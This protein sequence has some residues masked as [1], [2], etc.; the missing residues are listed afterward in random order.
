MRPSYSTLPIETLDLGRVASLVLDM[1]DLKYQESLRDLDDLGILGRLGEPQKCE[2]M[3]SY[4][5]S[6]SKRNNGGST[7]LQ[8][9]SKRIHS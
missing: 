5:N 2:V 6:S 1:K 7:Q 3:R 9:I 4:H 8:L